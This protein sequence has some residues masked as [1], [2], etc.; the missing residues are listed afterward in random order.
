[1]LIVQP[2]GGLCNRIRSVNS[3]R[4]LAEARNEK[5][6]VLWFLNKELNCPFEKLFVVN[7][8]I[9]KIH[10]IHT[11]WDL[12]K[13][14]YQLTCQFIPNDV[15][16]PHRIPI[17]QKSGLTPQS[18]DFFHSLK[19]RCY[20]ATEENF[21]PARDYSLFTPIPEIK[22]RVDELTEDFPPHTF[23]V[24][25]RRTDHIP[26]MESSTTGAF[27]LSMEKK[28]EDCPDAAFY[29]ATDDESEERKLRRA[30]P[31]KIISNPSR[32]LDRNCEAGIQDALTDL[33]ALSRTQGIIGSY[34]SSFTDTAADIGSIPKEI[35]GRGQ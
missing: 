9:L 17:G 29:L 31:G 15:I 20:L 3:A 2:I 25:V 28:L 35:A 30:F 24:H 19:N 4:G 11:K 13:L 26:A 14:Y 34:Y 6:L 12:S 10:T 5:L 1:M 32:T 27:I 23:G 21:Y 8:D 16:Y 7:T 33:L 22:R 18:L